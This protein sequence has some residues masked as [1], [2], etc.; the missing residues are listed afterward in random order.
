MEG[1]EVAKKYIINLRVKDIF[2]RGLDEYGYSQEY[3]GIENHL[4]NIFKDVGLTRKDIYPMLLEN[5]NKKD[6]YLV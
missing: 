4:K 1:Y 3:Y 5:V 6:F 2:T